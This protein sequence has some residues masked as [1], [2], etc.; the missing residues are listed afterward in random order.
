MGASDAGASPATTSAEENAYPG[1]VAW[2]GET[3]QL[4]QEGLQTEPLSEAEGGPSKDAWSTGAR[5]DEGRLTPGGGS[6]CNEG[7]S[8]GVGENGLGPG[9]TW[10]VEPTGFTELDTECERKAPGFG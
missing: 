5:R 1:G 8:T 6:A 3:N 2:T 10:K 9:L 4:A 7:S